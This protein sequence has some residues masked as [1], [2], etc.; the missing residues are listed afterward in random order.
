MKQLHKLSFILLIIGG[1]NWLLQGLFQWEVGQLFGGQEMMISRVI[2]VLVGL[3][4]IYELAIHTKSC[5]F[6]SKKM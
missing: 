6:C 4:A 1:L 2:Y 3:S 5:N